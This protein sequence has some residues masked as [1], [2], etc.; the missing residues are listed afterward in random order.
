MMHDYERHHEIYLAMSREAGVLLP[1]Q[2]PVSIPPPSELCE[3]EIA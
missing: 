2:E 3:Y 1:R